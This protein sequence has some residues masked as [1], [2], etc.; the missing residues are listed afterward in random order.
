[1]PSLRDIVTS[2]TAQLIQTTS[3]SSPLTANSIKIS[4]RFQA[5]PVP[6][7]DGDRDVLL[8]FASPY[9]V[10]DFV[11]GAGRIASVVYR[12]MEVVIRTR[13]QTGMI[14][15]DDTWL[16][17]ATL[18]HLAV[19]EFVVDRLHLFDPLNITGGRLLIEPM[20]V[21]SNQGSTYSDPSTYAVGQDRA[22]PS[23]GQSLIAFEFKYE[24]LLT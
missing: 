19:E 13:L 5:S 3:G 1:M 24:L 21:D 7:L 2:V 22:A 20:R 14:D 23:F 17:D 11:C 8:R 16:M 18:G 10:E 15:R 12:H 6:K 4:T 9:P